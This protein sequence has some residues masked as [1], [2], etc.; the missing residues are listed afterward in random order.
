MRRHLLLLGVLLL[1]FSCA[2][3]PSPKGPNDSLVIGYLALDFPDGFFEHS[4]R[5]ITTGINL[6]FLNETTG[7]SFWVSSS[8]GYF[9]FR[10]NGTD[11]YSLESF[12]VETSTGSIGETPVR[13]KLITRPHSLIY[14]GHLTVTYVR[15]T[16]KSMTSD[17]QTACWDFA[18]SSKLAHNEEELRA[19]LLSVDPGSPW[20]GY[21]IVR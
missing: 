10:S 16:R 21:E 13:R 9:Q 17:Q 15:P 8:D 4:K 14:L 7:K 5:A 20:L 6:K 1:C 12:K 18:I 2:S 19:Y 3:L 11:S